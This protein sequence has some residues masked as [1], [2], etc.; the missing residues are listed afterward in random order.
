MAEKASPYLFKYVKITTKN[1]TGTHSGSFW[2]LSS[3]SEM[4]FSN[5]NII[6]GPI[7]FRTCKYFWKDV[8]CSNGSQEHA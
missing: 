6:S 1:I 7:L 4:D 2:L 8:Q 5:V 3:K